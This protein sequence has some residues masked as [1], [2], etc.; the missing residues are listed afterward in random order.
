MKTLIVYDSAYGNTEQIAKAM[1]EAIGDGV[2]V[3][4]AGDVDARG[5]KD[6]ELVIV[7]SPTQG[8]RP[9]AL[10]KGFLQRIPDGSLRDTGVTAFDTRIDSAAQGFM[11]RRLM[12]V[13]GYAAGRIARQLEAKGGRLVTRPQ[14]FLVE[15][16]EGPL[17][18]G[19]IE[20][21][22]A[23]GTTIVRAFAASR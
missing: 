9:T 14:G 17:S 15:D 3:A 18:S 21:A 22:A 12:G 13:I 5:L 2:R 20:R 1:G 7:G 16:K 6:Y 4:R 10:V 23:W 8:G 19:E 11:L